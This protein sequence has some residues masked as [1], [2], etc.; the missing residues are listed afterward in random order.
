MGVRRL[1]IL[2]KVRFALSNEETFDRESAGFNYIVFFKSFVN[3]LKELIAGPHKDKMANILS[4][5]NRFVLGCLLFA[6]V[7][8]GWTFTVLPIGRFSQ[9]TMDQRTNR[10]LANTLLLTSWHYL[11]RRNRPMLLPLHQ[12]L[13][14]FRLHPHLHSRSID[15]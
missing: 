4:W 6:D 11:K 13:Q 8:T 3:F 14:L 2:S 9:P 7:L 15:I 1:T 10:N 5:W 12:S